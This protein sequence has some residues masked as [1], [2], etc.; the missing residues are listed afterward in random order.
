MPYPL[1]LC[2]SLIICIL[3]RHLRHYIVLTSSL[4]LEQFDAFNPNDLATKLSDYIDIFSTL[5][6]RNT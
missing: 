4:I 5:D 3:I 1:F 2:A 6:I